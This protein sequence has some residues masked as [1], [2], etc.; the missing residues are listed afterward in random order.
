MVTRVKTVEQLQRSTSL[1]YW[2]QKL[3]NL[4]NTGKQMVIF[5]SD[6]YNG[7]LPKWNLSRMAPQLK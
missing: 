2:H 3:V 7:S 5:A 1:Q 4:C 6:F